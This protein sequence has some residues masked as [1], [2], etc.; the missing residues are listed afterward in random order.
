MVRIPSF[1]FLVEF[2]S[3]SFLISWETG[4][5]SSLGLNT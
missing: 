4:N 2:G 5:E 3:C 1:S